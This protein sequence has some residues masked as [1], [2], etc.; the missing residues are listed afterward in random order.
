MSTPGLRADVVVRPATAADL[1]A[2]RDIYNHYVATSTCTFAIEPETAEEREAWLRDRG[3][4][5]PA[6][7]AEV[8]FT[9]GDRSEQ[10]QEQIKQMNADVGDD[11]ARAFVG[12]LPRHVV[13]AA[14]RRAVGQ[15]DVV[16]RIRGGTEPLTQRDQL[17]M[18]PQLQHGVDAA[19]RFVFELLECIQIPRVDDQRLFADGMGSYPQRQT[20][21][22]VVEI[23]RRADADVVHAVC[24]GTPAQLFEMPIESLDLGEEPDIE[25]ALV[26]NTDGVV[27]IRRRHQ[28]VP[29]VLDGFEMPRG[30]EPANAGHCEIFH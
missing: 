28:A 30:D 29:G 15:A 10:P 13:P 11:A 3:P 8:D 7:V 4:V 25:R 1:S 5:H 14:A 16:L 24:V 21:M 23:I 12:A 22:C 6:V 17:R 18:E 20:D 19:A 2:V 9:A 27:R 26:Q